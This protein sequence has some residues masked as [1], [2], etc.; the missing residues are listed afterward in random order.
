MEIKVTESK[1]KKLI[2]ILNNITKRKEL[3][4]FFEETYPHLPFEKLIKHWLINI[5]SFTDKEFIEDLTQFLEGQIKAFEKKDD[6]KIP[7]RFKKFRPVSKTESLIPK[8]I[9][10][11]SKKFNVVQLKKDDYV[12]TVESEEYGEMNKWIKKDIGYLTKTKDF[13]EKMDKQLPKVNANLDKV[14]KILIYL[15]QQE[16][17][18]TGENITIAKGSFYIKDI[19]KLLG[20]EEE[21]KLSGYVYKE[22]KRTLISGACIVY[23]YP[24]KIDGV[25]YKYYGSWYDIEVPEDNNY[26]WYYE[27][28]GLYGKRITELINTG[29]VQYLKHQLKEIADRN[30]TK[31][32]CLHYFYNQMVYSNL[33]KKVSNLLN[34]MGIKKDKLNRPKECFKILKDCLIYFYPEEIEGFYISKYYHKP[35]T[36][37]SDKLLISI[38][39]AFKKYEYED[40]KELLKAKGIKDIREAYISFKRHTGKAKKFKQFVLTESDKELIEEIL[41]WAEDWEE[42][43]EDNKIPFTKEERYKFLVDCIRLIGHEKLADSWINEQARETESYYGSYHVDDPIGYFTKRLP[44]L[45]RENKEEKLNLSKKHSS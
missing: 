19:A 39:E 2:N 20:Y 42:Y 5:E 11:L 44:E 6:L 45:L 40:F 26:K 31:E 27:F 37:L 29:Q 38:S 43:I 3:L 17:N 12:G 36:G 35:K 14:L 16:T 32:P 10:D 1:I 33:P 15:I 9:F 21:I 13:I 28:H 4:R 34:G 22:I 23:E 8:T 7:Q 30:T 25:N 41:L 18:K 24:H